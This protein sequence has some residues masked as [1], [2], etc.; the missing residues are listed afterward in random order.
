MNKE[1]FN[2]LWELCKI[3]DKIYK[4]IDK[5]NA[6]LEEIKKLNE[7]INDLKDLQRKYE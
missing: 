4:L 3:E 5:R 7:Q 1:N 6:K 2:K